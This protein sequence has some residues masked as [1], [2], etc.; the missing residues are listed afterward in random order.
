M[1][2][3]TRKNTKIM[4]ILSQSVIVINYVVPQLIE[5]TGFEARQTSKEQTKM[6]RFRLESPRTC[7]IVCF[8]LIHYA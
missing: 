3:R 2:T 5:R 7:T 6:P 8:A 1:S 4:R